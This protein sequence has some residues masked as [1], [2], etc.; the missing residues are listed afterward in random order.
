MR[1]PNRD[2]D[3]ASRS[4]RQ[5]GSRR[6]ETRFANRRDWTE[7][8]AEPALSE[9]PNSNIIREADKYVKHKVLLETRAFNFEICYRRVKHTNE[10]VINGNVYDEIEGVLEFPHKLTAFVDGHC[11]EV[12][13]TGTHSIISIDGENVA[14]KLRLF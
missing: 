9:T 5:N 12:G 4:R 7:E 8:N 3:K 6:N 11:I 2:R 14:K 1:C 13:F 10:L